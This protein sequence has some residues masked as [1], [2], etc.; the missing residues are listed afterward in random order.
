M[1]RRLVSAFWEI[2]GWEFIA[3]KFGVKI[4]VWLSRSRAK[5]LPRMGYIGTGTGEI[6]SSNKQGTIKKT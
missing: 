6:N 1:R 3:F 2:W 4:S 5:E